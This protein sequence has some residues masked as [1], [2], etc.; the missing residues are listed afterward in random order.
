MDSGVLVFSGDAGDWV[1][2]AALSLFG[3]CIFAGVSRVFT[4]DAIMIDFKWTIF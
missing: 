1:T 2:A 4:L 3:K